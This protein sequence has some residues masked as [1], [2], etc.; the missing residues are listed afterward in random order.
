[1]RSAEE[2]IQR[3]LDSIGSEEGKAYVALFSAWTE[4]IGQRISDHAQPA[5]VRGRTLVIE[6]DHPGWIQMV[7]ME[8]ERIVKELKRRFPELGISGISVRTAMSATGPGSPERNR[9]AQADESN[10]DMQNADE[11]TPSKDDKEA[12]KRIE[13]PEMRAA[14][15]R[16][17]K[18]IDT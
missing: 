18:E 13:D 2:L 9:R 6:A 5:D 16:L 4:I 8:K 7:L 14:L 12:L 3:Y 17:R 1:M 15:E 11:K 10:A